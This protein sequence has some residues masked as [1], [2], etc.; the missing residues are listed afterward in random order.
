MSESVCMKVS[1]RVSNRLPD[2]DR[3]E[4]SCWPGDF[5]TSHRWN[6]Q[7][8]SGV[9]GLCRA[10]AILALSACTPIVGSSQVSP[11]TSTPSTKVHLA[12]IGTPRCQPGA[13]RVSETG[14]P[15][16]GSDSSRGSFWALFFTPVPP[17]NAWCRQGSRTL[18][19][20][21]KEETRPPLGSF[22]DHQ[23]GCQRAT[24]RA[25]RGRSLARASGPNSYLDCFLLRARVHLDRHARRLVGPKSL[26]CRN[27]SAATAEGCPVR[28]R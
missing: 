12:T 20:V 23:L 8:I 22:Y 11:T 2:P 28:L 18:S 26:L 27:R 3:A 24:S 4:S 25:G 14:F 17:P 19:R 13:F 21:R 5:R 9:V 1:V 7:G 15:E 16:V 10:C 6:L